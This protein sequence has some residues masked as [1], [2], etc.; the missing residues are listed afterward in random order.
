MLSG[1]LTD[2]KALQALKRYTPIEVTVLGISNS[3]K[4]IQFAKALLPMVVR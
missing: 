3:S 1:K 4:D 2:A